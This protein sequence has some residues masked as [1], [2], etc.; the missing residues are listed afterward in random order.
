MTQIHVVLAGLQSHP[1]GFLHERR[2][3]PPRLVW[4]E[5]GGEGLG[6][7]GEYGVVNQKGK[8]AYDF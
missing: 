1:C 7:K 5:A 3:L 8:A 6:R 4:L 2:L